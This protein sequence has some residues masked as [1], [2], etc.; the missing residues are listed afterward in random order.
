MNVQE[1][2]VV[3][4]L[5]EMLQRNDDLARE[6]RIRYTGRE[7]APTGDPLIDMWEWQ[8]AHGITPDLDLGE[9]EATR[10]RDRRVA[11]AAAKQ[12]AETGDP[13]Y[14]ARLP[15]QIAGV[16][17]LRRAAEEMGLDPQG[18]ED[19]LTSSLDNIPPEA[20]DAFVNARKYLR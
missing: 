10:E 15:E 19:A 13:L 14:I 3:E 11:E 5:E 20:F 2:L 17:A 1:D 16:E 4:F 12:Y 6:L 9:D 7:I 8:I 18:V